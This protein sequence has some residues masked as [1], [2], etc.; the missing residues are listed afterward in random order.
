MNGA[1]TQDG[2]TEGCRAPE[3]RRGRSMK[4]ERGWR[5]EAM[6]KDGDE[7]SGD[8]T[9]TFDVGEVA[10]RGKLTRGSGYQATPSA[11]IYPRATPMFS[12]LQKFS[13]SYSNLLEKD[14]SS[15]LNKQG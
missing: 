2:R 11:R 15:F 4:A 5:A 13:K 9:F 10:V 3:H 8:R 14:F 12:N 7:G 6:T 1:T